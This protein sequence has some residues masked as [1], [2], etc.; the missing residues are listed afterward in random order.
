MSESKQM[1]HEVVLAMARVKE[2][3][4]NLLMILESAGCHVKSHHPK[5]AEAIARAFLVE[6]L[7]EE[8]S[9]G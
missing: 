9:N 7:I 4:S 1:V 6:C 3:R 8:A 5:H 2:A